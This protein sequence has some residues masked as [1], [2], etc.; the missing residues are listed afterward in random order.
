[1]F[2][3]LY[4]DHTGSLDDKVWFGCVRYIYITSDCL[5]LVLDHAESPYDQVWYGRVRYINIMSDCLYLDH[6]GLP[7][8]HVRVDCIRYINYIMSASGPRWFSWRPDLVWHRLYCINTMSDCLYLDHAGSP[9]DQVRQMCYIYHVCIWTALSYL[10]TRFG[11]A[12]YAI[13]T[14]YTWTTLGL[15]M[16]GFGMAMSAIITPC[17]IVYT[18]TMWVLL[19]TRCA[20]WA[21]FT[22]CL[23]LNHLELPDDQ[24]RKSHVCYIFYIISILDHAGS[25]VDQVWY[26]RERY[27]YIMSIPGP[28]WVS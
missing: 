21:I 11:R 27:I 25:P 2:D 23:Y 17:L 26:G 10:M 20:M 8:D 18:W 15:L 13:F 6:D 22:S 9:D 19:M 4:L 7:N 1:M 28:R 12:M 5:Y 3:C 24:V 14:L 16:R